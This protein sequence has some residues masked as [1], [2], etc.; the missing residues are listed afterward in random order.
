MEDAFEQAILQF[1]RNWLHKEA[2]DE[3]KR[4]LQFYLCK[5]PKLLPRDFISRLEALNKYM[6]YILAYVKEENRLG[7]WLIGTSMFTQK[8]LVNIVNFVIPK[9]WLNQ[10][11]AA[12]MRPYTMSLHNLKAYLP[13][14]QKSMD[15]DHMIP[16]RYRNCG[17]RQGQTRSCSRNALHMTELTSN[18]GI[19]QRT[20]SK[21]RYSGSSK[22]GYTKRRATN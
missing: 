21:K 9:A 6:M 3:L 1:F 4:Y 13:N 2:G 12:D 7:D 10:M 19:N 8:E 20:L 14:L 17:A 22:T 11:L 15:L 16:N 18:L 5:H